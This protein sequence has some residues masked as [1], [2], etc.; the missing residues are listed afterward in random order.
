MLWG[1]GV[2]GGLLA[3]RVRYLSFE[4]FLQAE[5]GNNSPERRNGQAKY[6][7][8][9]V[10]VCLVQLEQRVSKCGLGSPKSKLCL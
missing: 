7:G 8:E 10:R 4:G 1:I 3:G 9:T 2:E 5:M 6:T